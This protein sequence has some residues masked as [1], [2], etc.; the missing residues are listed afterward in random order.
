MRALA[1][2][3]VVAAC[4]DTTIVV[5][6]LEEVAQ[7]KAIPNRELDLLFVVDNSGS[8]ADDQVRLAASFPRMIDTLAQ[9]DDGVPDI[10]I[11]VITT[12]LGTSSTA[13]P[14]GSGVIGS[15]GTGGCAGTG[16][17]GALVQGASVADR[18][19]RDGGGTRNYTGELRDAFRE[20]ALVG[21]TGCGFE[22][23]LAAIRRALSNPLNAGF[24]RP[25]ANL[26]VVILSDEDDCSAL[27]PALFSPESPALGALHSFRCF[28]FGVECAQDTSAIGRK[29]DCRPRAG[30]PYVEDVAPFVELLYA[31]KPDPRMVMVSGIVG[32]PTPVEVALRPPP[33]AG[34]D[35]PTLVPSCTGTTTAADP[36]VRLDAFISAFAPRGTL[37]SICHDDVSDP[38]ASIATTTKRLMNDPCL[39]TALLADAD[40][41]APGVQPSCEVVDL[42]DAAPD[43]PLLIPPCDSSSTDCFELVADE[44]ACPATDDHLRVSIRRSR[45][46]A[47]DTWTHVRCQPAP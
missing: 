41:H 40:D 32:D 18:F 9:L 29:T 17:D 47:D 44:A 46:V 3:L 26:A 35:V 24:V 43:A 2:L 6:G 42:R 12:D 20:L 21:D 37:T 33:G 31:I 27:D 13:M 22:Q 7:L 39:D 4:H 36:A 5:G 1:G 19:I 23:P 28:R 16:D 10:H 11:G 15:D 25:E 38:L 45:P 30:S 34:A 8:M 14:G